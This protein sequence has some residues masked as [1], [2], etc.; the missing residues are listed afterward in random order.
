MVNDNWTNG[1]WNEFFHTLNPTEAE[2]Q[3]MKKTEAFP[4]GK[5]TTHTPADAYQRV[6]DYAGASLRRDAVDKRYISELLSGTATYTGSL[7]TTP[8]LGIIDKV[9]DTDGYPVLKS[10]PAWP[11]TDAD[12]IPDVWEEAYGLNKNSAND[13]KTYT[14][15]NLSRY[16]NL[17][18]YFH[19]LVQHIVYNQNLGGTQQEKK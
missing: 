14:L 16:T 6:A 10:L 13:A 1:I 9:S 11:D 3:A 12:G 8:K 4:F 19:N 15:D 2:K 5:V 17:E 7:S 18:V